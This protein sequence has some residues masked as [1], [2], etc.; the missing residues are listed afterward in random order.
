MAAIGSE[1]H[2][3]FP[4]V[5]RSLQTKW[6]L[7]PLFVLLRAR[8]ADVESSQTKKVDIVKCCRG[9]RLGGSATPDG[10]RQENGRLRPARH[11]RLSWLQLQASPERIA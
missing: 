11:S 7:Y 8:G 4:G 9:P 10:H 1:Q 3:I 2:R 6:P 5:A